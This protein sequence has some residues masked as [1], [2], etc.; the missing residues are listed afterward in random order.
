MTAIQT[1]LNPLQSL[2][3]YHQSVWLDYIRRSLIT[4][5]ELKRMVDDGEIWGVTSNP[6]IFQK[7][8]AGSSD[9][10]AALT[11]LEQQHDL[12]V[13]SLYEAFA[14]ADIQATA[15]CLV[16]SYQKTHK[17]DGYVSLEV[18]PYLSHDT[19]ATVSEAHR[20]WQTVNRPNLMI[21]VPATPAG[22]PAIQQLIGDGINVNVTLLFDRD[23]Y[24]RVANAYIT[25]LESFAA[26]GGDVSQVASVASFFVSR[27]DT[28]M[29][30]LITSRLKTT[31]ATDEREL[32]KTMLGQMAIANAKVTY[33]RYQEIYQSAG[34]ASPQG[35]RWQQL[36]NRGAKPQRL[37]WAS[38]GTKDP[39]YSD[40]LYVE[41][42][43]GADTVNTIPPATL[44]AFREH[45]HSRA[46]LSENLDRAQEMMLKPQQA[47]ISFKEI[48][49]RLLTDGLQQF[50]EAFD[51]LLGAIAQKR[52]AL[53]GNK[54]DRL[55]YLLPEDLD[56]SV[57]STITDWHTQGK[58][59]QLWAHNSALWTG[60]DE[61]SWLGWLGV[62]DNL[63]AHLDRLKQLAQDVKELKFS[64]IVLLGM[65]G[66]SLCPDVL[67]STF[68]KLEG[69]PE[70]LVLDSTDPA[71]IQAIERKIDLTRS[72][73]IVSSKSGTTLEPN[74]FKQY[75]FDRVRQAI[76][77]A[78][79]GDRFI[80]ITDPKSNLQQVAE[81]DHFRDIFF[82]VPS[83]GGRYSA[84]SNFGMVPAAAMGIDVTRF[85]D[86]AEE[87][88]HSCAAAVPAEENPGVVLG[89]ILGT[90]ATQGRDKVTLVASHGIADLGGWLEQ[91]LAESTGKDG[92]GIIPIAQEPLGTPDVYGNDR[93]FVYIRL[94]AAADVLQD[95]AIAAL[96]RSGQPVIRIAIAD[97]YQL[98]QEFF[99]WEIATAVAGS[100]I[101]IDAFNQPD[102]EASKIA[103]R[104]LTTAYERAGTLPPETPILVE[105]GIQLF[106]D[107]KNAAVL[108]TAVGK[109]RSLGGYLRAHFDRVKAGDYVALL[110]YI[111]RNELHQTQLQTLRQ[112]VRAVKHV[113]TCVGFGPRFLHSTGQAYKGGPNTGVFLQITCDDAIDLPVPQQKYSFSVVKAAQARGDLQVLADR[114]RRAVRVH[115]GTDV[116]AGLA[117]L[118]Q[119]LEQILA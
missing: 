57:R 43:I 104:Q 42:L 29:D 76:G 112:T 90:L 58:I 31:T 32:L 14:I 23:V 86:A 62:T 81:T 101:G 67:R 79:A 119:M 25:G 99:R 38:T 87:M 15:D 64:H 89:V 7:A 56:T 109:D 40:V 6:S 13:M 113:A 95:Q 30:N 9:Y 94:D 77:T 20:L 100:I 28:A 11:S 105:A 22:I 2:Q 18:S 46:S 68:G 10:D 54:L 75:F 107:P 110:A 116:R 91:L 71:Q 48:T 34:E 59:R 61:G 84:L 97:A 69:Y 72:L 37:L 55:T 65:G 92:K 24:E 27:I 50:S 39:Q 98:G 88:V 1:Q 17:H 19:E 36:A 115:L 108:S 49:D 82:G 52:A 8:I 5:G 53:L 114:D 3:S 85:L 44:S 80:A 4:S 74:I 102:V 12:N 111:E 83:I 78:S 33:H 66:S 118:Q 26:K 47:G 63:I 103:T 16:P 41:E 117:M 96:E 106:I 73:F 93:L 60:A 35:S 51:G 45:G 21:K 70:L